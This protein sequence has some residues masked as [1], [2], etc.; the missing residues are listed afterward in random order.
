[1]K[2]KHR[3]FTLIELLASI[4][5][6]IIL[7]GITFGGLRYAS[8]K[9]DHDKTLSI[10]TEFE[11]ALEDYKHDYGHYPIY[12][13]ANVNSNV[14]HPVDFSNSK[15]DNFTN[16]NKNNKKGKPY[17]EN[18]PSGIL[19]DA[20]DNGIYYQFPNTVNS[21]NISKFALCSKGEDDKYGESA[22]TNPEDAG[23]GNCDDI[24]N[25]KQN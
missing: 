20:Y 16:K 3:Q 1:M 5:I 6:I 17:M 10:M 12:P 19:K 13:P 14:D 15:W 4:A 7:A 18:I 2:T 24:C 21:R 9:A 23:S 11:N 8:A 22:T 25:W